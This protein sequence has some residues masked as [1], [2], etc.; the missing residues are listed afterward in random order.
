MA[1]ETPVVPRG[2]A[3]G[4]ALILATPG[5]ARAEG[6]SRAEAAQAFQAALAG[7]AGAAARASELY[8]ALSAAAPGDPVLLAYA[9][10][11]QTLVARG[12]RSPLDA[13][14]LAETGLARIDDAV[15][16]LGP[17]H[18]E[19]A[20]GQLPASFETCLVAASTFLRVPD[21]LFHR[22]GDGEV[23]LA[24][25]VAHPAVPHLPASLRAQ[26]ARLEAGVARAR[27]EPEAELAA[28]R[29]AIALD[30]TGPETRAAQARA[31][32]LAP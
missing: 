23:V 16:R 21:Q 20:P 4:L 15:A 2:L 22:L 13:L 32:E 6:R 14:R 9:G 28:L 18:E 11:A 29:R 5:T 1:S 24:R 31:A 8:D 19:A 12:A 10:A 26:L 7:D 27:Y 30:P 17:A 25:A 3:L